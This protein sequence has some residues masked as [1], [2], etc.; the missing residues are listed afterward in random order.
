MLAFF[1]NG[2]SSVQYP[3]TVP[4]KVRH[5]EAPTLGG[6][7]LGDLGH[8]CFGFGGGRFS[9]SGRAESVGLGDFRFLVRGATRKLSLDPFRISGLVLTWY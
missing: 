6:G 9:R 8:G 2:Y 5:C 3:Y 1:G 7:R 4:W